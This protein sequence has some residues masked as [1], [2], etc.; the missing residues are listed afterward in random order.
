[1]QPVVGWWWVVG[2]GV[3]V[4]ETLVRE[5]A[6]SPSHP[7]DH[8]CAVWSLNK[9]DGAHVPT[10]DRQE[11]LLLYHRRGG[12]AVVPELHIPQRADGDKPS[13]GREGDGDDGGVE[14]DVREL[15]PRRRGACAG[16]RRQLPDDHTI[17]QVPGG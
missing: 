8:L 5:A 9:E 10:A 4:V 3:V 11:L 12:A 13:G 7:E 16:G 17:G 1:M 15:H 14:H 2:G 6:A